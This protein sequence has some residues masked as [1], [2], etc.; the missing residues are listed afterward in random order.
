MPET[1]SKQ[2][3]DNFAKARERYL[4]A[5]KA[6]GEKN[7]LVSKTRM[8]WLNVQE[9][10]KGDKGRLERVKTEYE[11]AKTEYEVAKNRYE[12]A[13]QRLLDAQE[14]EQEGKETIR[15][16][17]ERYDEA[18]NKADEADHTQNQVAWDVIETLTS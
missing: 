13:Q 2:Q 17:R 18:Q 14:Y 7:E 16:A 4:E 9:R 15:E 3:I 12:K 1:L 5:T 8:Q 10:H 6:Q 11:R